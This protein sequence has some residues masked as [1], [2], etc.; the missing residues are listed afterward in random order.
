TPDILHEYLQIGGRPAF[1]V[2]LVLA[3][4]LAASYGIYSGFE[5]CEN[6]AAPGT[7]EYR[8]SEKYQIRAWDW[9]RPGN[10]IDLVAKVN[11]IRHQNRALHDND[12]L[13]FYAINN[14][15]IIFYAKTTE[16]LSNIIMVAVN[17]DTERPQTGWVQIPLDE[18]GIG[19]DETFQVHDLISNARY[20]WRGEFN[21]IGLDPAVCPAH[22]FKVRRKRSTKRD[23]DHFR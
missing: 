18:I 4:T 8:N 21:Y 10:I 22:I 14:D 1:Q 19:K 7:E 3:A 20:L 5:L 11:K 12:R 23:F 16:D 15:Q 9:D 6:R 17:L 2:R 13:R